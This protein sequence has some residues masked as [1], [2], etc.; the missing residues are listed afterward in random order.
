MKLNGKR[1]KNCPNKTGT[2]DGL[3]GN[4]K[5][6]KRVDVHYENSVGS[7]KTNSGWLDFAI[8][9]LSGIGAVIGCFGQSYMALAM[10]IIGSVSI[11]IRKQQKKCE[12]AFFAVTLA[13]SALA[14]ICGIT[15]LL[16]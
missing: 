4:V 8:L 6:K 10:G 13:F 16:I 5:S 15:F 2:D 14:I 12:T 11:I 3:K 1:E 7:V 9:L